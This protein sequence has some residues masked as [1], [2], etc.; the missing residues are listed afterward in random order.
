MSLNDQLQDAIE[1]IVSN[2]LSTV[3]TCIPGKI[4]SYDHT[5][6]M[7]N[8]QPLIK[9][10]YVDG[11]TVNLPVIVNVPVVWM[12]GGGALFTFPLMQGDG[13]LLLFAERNIDLWLTKGGI[14][15]PPDR[16]KFDLSDCIAIP[17]LVDFTNSNFPANNDDVMLTYSGGSFAVH[18]D[19][20]IDINNGNL[21]VDV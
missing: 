13:V 5:K 18:N 4:E 7:A 19:G 9:K 2:V 14:V 20:Q 6:Q 17:G 16:R 1:A 12:R 11:E 10:K 3:H 21:T 15:G 8:V